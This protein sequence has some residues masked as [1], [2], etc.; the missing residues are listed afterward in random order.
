MATNRIPWSKNFKKSHP[1]FFFLSKHVPIPLWPHHPNMPLL[2]LAAGQMWMP[3]LLSAIS[4]LHKLSECYNSGIHS[5]FAPDWPL[6]F[7]HVLK[8]LPM[9]ITCSFLNQQKG[10]QDPARGLWW[11]LPPPFQHPCGIFLTQHQLL[12]L[13]TVG[14]NFALEGMTPSRH[15]IHVTYLLNTSI[16]CCTCQD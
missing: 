10:P 16:S 15:S 4:S 13:M 6:E 11:P 1:P 3:F 5:K 12:P 2:W 9:D 14:Y 7:S 8:G